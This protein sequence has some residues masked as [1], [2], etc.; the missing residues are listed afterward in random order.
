MEK[1]LNIGKKYNIPIL[2]DAA[3]AIGS[4]YKKKFAGTLGDIGVFLFM[5]QKRLPLEKVE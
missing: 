5:E 4:K 2:E 3:E 1:I